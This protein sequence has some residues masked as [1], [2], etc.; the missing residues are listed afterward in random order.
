MWRDCRALSVLGLLTILSCANGPSVGQEPAPAE[1]AGGYWR[2][3]LMS[4]G[5][6]TGKGTGG[7]AVSSDG[8]AELL[9]LGGEKTCTTTLTMSQIAA[10]QGAVGSITPEDWR[11]GD[12][13]SKPVCCDRFQWSL[14]VTRASGPTEEEKQLV[15]SWTADTTASEGAPP[16]VAA[17]HEA[18]VA[19]WPTIRSACSTNR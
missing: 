15:S 14:E 9:Q 17:V 10:L 16:G 18:L 6:I 2:T 5:G 8:S 7:V 3:E 1:P 19:L 13:K 4:S 12:R 11:A